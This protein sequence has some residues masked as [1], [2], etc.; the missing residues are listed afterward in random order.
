VRVKNLFG[1]VGNSMNGLFV[2]SIGLARANMKTGMKNLTC[3]T[4]G[5]IQ[6]K[7]AVAIE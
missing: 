5:C 3:N 7:L 2:Q 6:I 4:C 1:F